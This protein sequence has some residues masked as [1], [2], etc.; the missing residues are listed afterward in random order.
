MPWQSL[1]YALADAGYDVWIGNT[2][3]NI[4]SLGHVNYTYFDSEFWDFSW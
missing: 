1:T 2:R 3:G 4:Y